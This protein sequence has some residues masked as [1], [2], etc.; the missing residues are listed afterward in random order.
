MLCSKY[1]PRLTAEPILCGQKIGF[2]RKF[3]MYWDDEPPVLLSETDILKGNY[4][5]LSPEKL[6]IRIA[7]AMKSMF[8][9]QEPGEEIRQSLGFA[10]NLSVE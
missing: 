3:S 4:R 9:K 5:K 6:Q 1:E 8:S 10:S 7:A 2:F